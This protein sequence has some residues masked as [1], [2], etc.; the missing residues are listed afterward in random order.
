MNNVDKRKV[1]FNKKNFIIIHQYQD[2]YLII[3]T[4]K[5]FNEGHTHVYGS[6]YA[7]LLVMTILDK[8]LKTKHLRMLKNKNFWISMERLTDEQFVDRVK[9]RSL[10]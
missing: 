6:G 7:K 1:I 5:D 3:N 10:L 2:K 9:R 4:K 8:K